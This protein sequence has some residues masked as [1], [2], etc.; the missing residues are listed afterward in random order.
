MKQDK[1]KRD[2]PTTDEEMKEFL[3]TRTKNQKLRY[4][5]NGLKLSTGC[6][7]VHHLW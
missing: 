5:W 6:L 2:F 3:A 1:I 4:K 7:V